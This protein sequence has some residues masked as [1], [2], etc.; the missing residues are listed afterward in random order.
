MS[1]TK[2]V[3]EDMIVGGAIDLHLIA[4]LLPGDDDVAGVSASIDDSAEVTRGGVIGVT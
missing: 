4:L 1:C 3:E 2:V